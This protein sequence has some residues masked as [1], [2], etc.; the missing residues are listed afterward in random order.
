M[1]PEGTTSNNYLYSVSSNVNGTV[2]TITKTDITNVWNAERKLRFNSTANQERF[3]AYLGTGS[4][5]DVVLYKE[6]QEESSKVGDVNGDGSVT[7]ADVTALVNILLNKDTTAYDLNAADVDGE[8]GITVA[9]VEA[10]VNI[11]LEKT[12]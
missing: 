5:Q 3:C 2:W 4:Q 1:K 7:I 10:L 11:I 12:N 8:P 9:D 6:L